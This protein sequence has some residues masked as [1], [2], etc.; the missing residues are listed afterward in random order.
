MPAACPGPGSVIGAR[1]WA[2][3]LAFGATL[4]RFELVALT[5]GDVE[6]RCGP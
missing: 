4:H 3:L 5:L 2:V 1:D 6:N